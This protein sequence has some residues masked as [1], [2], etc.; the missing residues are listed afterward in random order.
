MRN[1][2]KKHSG[3]IKRNVIIILAL[4]CIAIGSYSYFFSQVPQQ[5]AIEQTQEEKISDTLETN[6]NTE[7]P[8]SDKVLDEQS[9]VKADLIVATPKITPIIKTVVAVAPKKRA[10]KVLP[11]LDNSDPLLIQK[12][13][14]FLRNSEQRRLLINIG[15]VRNFVVFID[16]FSRGILLTQFSNFNAP[17]QRF[18]IEKQDHNLFLNKKS[19]QRYDIYAN[20]I[21]NMNTALVIKEYKKLQPLFDEAYSDLGYPKNAF[22]ATLSLAIEN[23]LQAP[24]LEG[25]I[26]LV[27]PSVMYRFA[28]EDLESL[29]ATQKLLI[30]MGP[31]NSIKI[32]HKLREIQRA[33]DKLS[34]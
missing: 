13:R 20:V 14:S 15:I 29:P 31:D 6:L 28:D 4:L 33:L 24:I 26:L 23:V 19:Y 25:N 17:Q 10:S 9:R 32:K 21:A 8:L 18:L 5:L 3:A 12:S 2:Q 16:N 1:S 11:Q 27:A 34:N 7:K 22:N 30:R